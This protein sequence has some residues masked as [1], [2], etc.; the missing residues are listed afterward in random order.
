MMKKMQEAANAITDNKKYNEASAKA[1]V[2][3]REAATVIAMK[4]ISLIYRV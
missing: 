3:K 2:P 4:K 1:D